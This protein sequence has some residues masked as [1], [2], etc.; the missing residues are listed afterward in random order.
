MDTINVVLADDHPVVRSGIRTLLEKAPDISVVGEASDGYE[1]LRLVDNLK[2]HVLLLDMELP[3]LKGIEVA[4]QLKASGATVRILAL[5]AYDDEQY[6][7]GL[8]STGAVGYMTKDE[9]LSTIT[10]AVRGVAGGEVGWLSRRVTAKVMQRKIVQ[11]QPAADTLTLL[12]VRER[13]VLQLVA[14]GM[15]N[16][17]IRATLC[18]SD[19]TVKNHITNIYGKLGVRTRAEAVAW[20]WRHGLADGT[21]EA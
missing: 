20:A 19:G 12:S 10:D 8:F 1:T 4:Q 7:F 16:E 2:P 5:S 11:A 6:I 14:S 9:A 3:G 18:I 21:A 15:P 13:Q 17:Q